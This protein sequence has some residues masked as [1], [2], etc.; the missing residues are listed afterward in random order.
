MC[1][2]KKG[3]I[4]DEEL[5]AVIDVQQSF[6]EKQG[7]TRCQT[8]KQHK[9]WKQMT[10]KE[11]KDAIQIQKRTYKNTHEHYG[12]IYIITSPSGKQFIGKSH[13]LFHKNNHT[14]FLHARKFSHSVLLKETEEYG[15]ENMTVEPLASCKKN[16]LDHYQDYYINEYNTLAPNGLNSKKKVK[17][18]VKSQIKSQNIIDRVERQDANGE[19]LPKYVKF[20]DWKDRRGYA[21]VSHPRCKLKYFV[22]NKKPLPTLKEQ[23]IAFLNSLDKNE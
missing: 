2:T 21:V 8:D 10:I 11:V 16:M 1:N 17:D 9:N 4:T 15:E 20:I 18:E 19:Q 13:L 12:H 7:N 22:S 3:L 14:L 6:K 5:Q 23:C